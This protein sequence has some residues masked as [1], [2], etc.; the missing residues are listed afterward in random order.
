MSSDVATQSPPV[1]LTALTTMRGVAALW[2][3]FFH[4]DVILFYRDFGHLM[5]LGDS[6]LVAKGYLWVDFFF[7]LSGFIIYHIY[8]GQFSRN[9]TGRTL[10]NFIWGRFSRIYPLHL[11]TLAVLIGFS[12]LLP[13]FLPSVVDDSW[14]LYFDT[15]A[16]PSNLLLTNAMNQH[17][18]LSWN[19]VSWSIGAEW[20][21]YMGGML[22]LVLLGRRSLVVTSGVMGL[23]AIFLVGLVYSRAEPTLDITFDRGFFRCL[24]DFTI[25]VGLYQFYRRS[26]AF[27]WL[28]KDTVFLG[29]F[30]AVV[31][32]F[33]GNWHDLWIIPL[34]SMMILALA[35]NRDL[36]ARCLAWTPLHYLGKISYSVYLMHGVWFMV[37]WFLLP[38]WASAP[39]SPLDRLHFGSAFLGLTLMSAALTYPLIEVRS[40]RY[41]RQKFTFPRSS[42]AK[43]K[44]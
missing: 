37:F 35:Y 31:A 22:L 9:V 36:V 42:L 38:L 18:Y 41:L 17:S 10:V 32:H 8:G 14:T 33:H 3:V 34:F 20:W 43:E 28:K 27:A 19:I 44:I 5:P 26:V 29:L 11:F 1:Y 23:A 2:V 6:G 16:L 7:L 21:A 15:A 39:F 24:F 13:L 30:L 40:R 25:G 12:S 4:M